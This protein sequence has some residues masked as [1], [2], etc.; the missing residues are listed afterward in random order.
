[1]I[2]TV[3]GLARPKEVEEEP[4]R[5]EVVDDHAL[6]AMVACGQALAFEELTKRHLRSMVAVAQRILGSAAEADEVAQEAFLRLWKQAFKWDADG[7]ASVKTWLSRVTT[8][9]CLDRLRQRRTVPLEEAGEVEDLSRG[10]MDHLSQQD[11]KKL[12]QEMLERLPERQRVAVILSYFEEMSCRDVA[13]VMDLTQGAVESLL[14][15]A[16]KSLR[17]SARATGLVWGEDL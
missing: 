14:V 12:V 15:R 6:M 11:R 2:G 4:E 9:L 1:M 16:R 10:V 8:N 5:S 3:G 7:A 13:G 17:E